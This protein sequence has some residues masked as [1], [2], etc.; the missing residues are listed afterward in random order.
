MQL[1]ANWR[2]VLRH[3]WSIKFMLAAGVFTGLEF[4]LPYVRDY[5]PIGSG[6]FTALAFIATAGGLIT[7]LLAQRN[8]QEGAP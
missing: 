4:I 5:L 3:A 2:A 8:T 1:I 7:R 6:W